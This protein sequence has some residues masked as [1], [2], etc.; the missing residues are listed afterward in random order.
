MYACENDLQDTYGN[1]EL[2]GDLL[3]GHEL[4]ISIFIVMNLKVTKSTD[5]FILSVQKNYKRDNNSLHIL[6]RQQKPMCIDKQAKQK[7]N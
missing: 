3:M 1:F 7:E 2:F 4:D 5:A 6:S